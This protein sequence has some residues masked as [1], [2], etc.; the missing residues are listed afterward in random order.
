MATPLNE[1]IDQIDN[2][3]V[4]ISNMGDID[5]SKFKTIMLINTLGGKLEHIQSQIHGMADDPSFSA[6]K[7]VHCIHH[8]RDLVK[9]HTA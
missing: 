5:W 2:L 4:H 8:E 7:I 9:H 6:K 3:V 1:T